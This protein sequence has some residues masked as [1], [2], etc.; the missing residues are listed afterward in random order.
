M[1]TYSIHNTT[2]GCDLGI[3][4]GV[5]EA[6]AYL[7]MCRDAGHDPELDEMGQPIIPDDLVITKI[8]AVRS[9]DR[10]DVVTSAPGGYP[11]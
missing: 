4:H 2:S 8:A 6:D 7:D 3:F 11:Y 10:E 5:S 1:K 9:W